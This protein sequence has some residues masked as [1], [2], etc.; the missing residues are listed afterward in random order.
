[1]LTRKK[2]FFVFVYRSRHCVV[3]SLDC[4]SRAAALAR[5]TFALSKFLTS[6]FSGSRNYATPPKPHPPSCYWSF[7]RP[8][9]LADELKAG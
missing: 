2:K 9:K 8:N 5:S 6:V 3:L 4:M 1:M 7:A